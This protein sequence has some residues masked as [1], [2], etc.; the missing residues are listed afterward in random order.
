[1][2]T[3]SWQETLNRNWVRVN[4][5]WLLCVIVCRETWNPRMIA[6]C[7]LPELVRA[8]LVLNPSKPPFFSIFNRSKARARTPLGPVRIRTTSLGRRAQQFFNF[9][10]LTYCAP[11]TQKYV[12]KTLVKVDCT[13]GMDLS[14]T[15]YRLYFV[16]DTLYTCVWESS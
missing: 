15:L 4:S 9:L 7:A 5:V 1:V 3:G 6:N 11:N 14:H 12:C 16:T 10:A 8:K 13:K 2:D